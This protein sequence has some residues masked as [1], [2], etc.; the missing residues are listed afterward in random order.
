MKKN[1]LITALIFIMIIPSVDLAAWTDLNGSVVDLRGTIKDAGK[2]LMSLSVVLF[3]WGIV[4]FIWQDKKEEGKS[5]MIWG[6]IG[7]FVLFTIWG[8]VKF[9]QKSVIDNDGST[10]VL[11]TVEIV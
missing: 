3:F 1:I 2:L 4:K 9:L 5:H 8:L 7:L 10:V 6:I 11:P